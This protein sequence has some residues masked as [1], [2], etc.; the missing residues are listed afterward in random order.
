M[1]VTVLVHHHDQLGQRHQVGAPD[2]VHHLLCVLRVAL[3]DRHDQTVVEDAGGRHVVVDDVRDQD[4]GEWQE[5]PLGGLAQAV[6]LLRRL[7][8]D[9]RVVNRVLAHGHAL[10]VQHRE[11]LDRG[12]VTGVVTERALRHPLPR[13]QI[14]LQDH[15]RVRRDLQRDGHAVDH[16]DPLAAEETGE[17]VLVDVAGQ[18]G[19]RGVAD[20]RVGADRDRH[21]QTLPQP[22]GDRVVRGRV[23]VDLPVHAER[24]PRML[25]QAVEAQVALAGLRVLGVGQP[26]VVEDPA[27]TGPDLQAG[28]P[29]QVH[30]V[31]LEHD[32]LAGRGLHLPRRD[33]LELQHLGD[34]LADPG[35]ADRQ[36]RLGQRTDPLP[37]LV[38]RLHAERHRHPL[39]GAEQV[40]RDRHLT[41]RRLLEQ[42]R[43]ATG[44]DSTGHHLADLQ[45]R[46]H[47]DGD[48]AQLTGLL[49][50]GEEALQIGIGKPTGRH[51]H[52]S[53]TA[54]VWRRAGAVTRDL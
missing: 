27:V 33:R 34:A 51:A 5:D 18:W 21:R 20:H 12:V 2:G 13:L 32:L 11:R 30:L 8:R 40:D 22:L 41:A 35:P 46:V 54:P 47:R 28:Q 37:D 6:I 10:D 42:Q 50:R 4:L 38:Q 16:L 52:Q 3:T 43:R 1:N 9:D 17:Q 49:Q 45:R 7:R 14:A 25:L 31:T 26:E 53:G 36:L 23:L 15:L 44:A 48:P 19:A 39:L 24:V 29:A